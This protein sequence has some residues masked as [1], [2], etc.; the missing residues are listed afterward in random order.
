MLFGGGGG[1]G[2]LK[3]FVTVAVKYGLLFLRNKE[4]KKR[5]KM[6]KGFSELDIGKALIKTCIGTHEKTI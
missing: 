1:Q 4:R 2:N 3:P 6:W 5:M